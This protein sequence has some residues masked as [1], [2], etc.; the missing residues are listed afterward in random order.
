M[1]ITRSARKVF[2]IHINVVAFADNSRKPLIAKNN[3]ARI[4]PPGESDLR[5]HA[6]RAEHLKKVKLLI[7]SPE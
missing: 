7:V 2:S 1:K 5:L 4:R 6:A 3:I